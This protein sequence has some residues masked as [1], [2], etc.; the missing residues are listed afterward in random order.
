M[1]PSSTTTSA[2]VGTS[3]GV[4]PKSSVPNDRRSS[5][6]P[7]RPITVPIATSAAV[8]VEHGRLRRAS[9]RSFA[10]VAD[11][12]DDLTIR[13]EIVQP[14]RRT[15][16]YEHIHPLRDQKSAGPTPTMVNAVRFNVMGRP[17]TPASAPKLDRQRPSL[18]MT[19]LRTANMGFF[20]GELATD[21]RLH[22]QRA[23]EVSG[24]RERRRSG[25]GRQCGARSAPNSRRCSPPIAIC[26][27][28][29]CC[30]S[31]SIGSGPTRRGRVCS[32]S[33]AVGS[34]R[35]AG[36]ACRRWND[37]VAPVQAHRGHRGVLRSPRALRRRRVH[38]HDPQGRAAQRAV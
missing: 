3:Y 34:R 1:T 35:F 29:T 12:A 8:T 30:A 2:Y 13:A 11:D 7:A 17:T 9:H 38:Q 33:C 14:S 20:D 18:M 6:E 4:T 10:D 19:A 21:W 27:Q 23:K 25:A 22:T 31:S 15:Q 26:S 24:D 36:S 5:S 16:R 37:S 28:R 32:I